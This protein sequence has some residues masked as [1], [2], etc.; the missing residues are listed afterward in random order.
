M[1]GAARPA[2]AAIARVVEVS[3]FG[4]RAVTADAWEQCRAAYARFALPESW[5]RG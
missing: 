2:F 5:H 3:A 4:S 1:P